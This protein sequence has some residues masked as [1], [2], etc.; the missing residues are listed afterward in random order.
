MKIGMVGIE[1]KHAEFFGSLI[2]K[3]KIIPDWCVTHICPVDAPERLDYVQEHVNA[4]CICKNVQE[5]IDSVDAVLV[6]TRARETHNDYAI[7]SIKRGKPTFV[8]KPFLR[9]EL[10]ARNLLQLARQRRVPLVGGSTFCFLPEIA[11]WKALLRRAETVTLRYWADPDSPFGG[12]SFYGSHMTDVATTLF[13]RPNGVYACRTDKIVTS[14][15]RYPKR[16]VILQTSSEHHML[17]VSYVVNG[18]TCVMRMDD[19]ACYACGMKAFYH[20]IKNNTMMEDVDR[21]ADSVAVL[22]G[23]LKSLESGVEEKIGSAS[24]RYV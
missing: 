10:Q 3:E 23:I 6:I 18:A 4:K 5:M 9:D 13:W 1:S 17:E 24:Y 16:Q 2:N 14:V 8:D 12:Y 19:S 7:A 22:N 11:H 21:L 15:L 20:A